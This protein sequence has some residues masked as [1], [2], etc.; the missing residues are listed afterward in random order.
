[1][2]GTCTALHLAQRGHSVALVDRGAPGGET[3]YGN[4]GIIQ[5]EAV[6]P[7]AFPRDWASLFNVAFKRGMD[8]NYHFGALPFVLPHLA[9][10]WQAS[11][12]SRYPRIAAEFSRLIEHSISENASLIAQA[13]ADDL[14]RRTGYRTV[15]RTAK[16]FD[17]AA[18]K[19]RQLALQH[20]IRHTLLDSAALARAEPAL[21]Q[22]LAGALHWLEPWSVNDP[23]EL[24]ARYA[25]LFTQCSGRIVQGDAA[26]LRQ[27][28]G[29]WR[30]L[31]HD[32]PLE[33]QHAV[34]ALGPWA[35]TVTRLLGYRLPLFVK[36]GYHR[37]YAPA[38]GVAAP[39]LSMPLLDAERGMVLAPMLRGL[40][41]TTGAEFARIGAPPT[42]VQL[43]KAEQAA[44]EIIDLPHAVEAQPWLGNRPCTPDMKPVIGP[45]PRHP[46]LWFNFGHAHQGFT[47]GAVS[48]RLL[49]D[50]LE[51]RTPFVDAAPYSARR[52]G[53]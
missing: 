32:G 25:K 13:G 12:P 7:Y 27:H 26:S 11:G 2:V 50:L 24:V 51:G 23:G 46:G 39:V 15:F 53:C 31:A 9:R 6:Q 18:E 1:M 36:R 34:I 30:V 17:Q 43:H 19:A 3:S 28:A 35:D 49:A 29:R 16:A 37:H 4:S 21:R 5:R 40:R 48:G 45:A 20:G 38:Q 42:P 14:I 44:R 10:Y 52:F 33:A 47:L 22:S 8:V 41:I